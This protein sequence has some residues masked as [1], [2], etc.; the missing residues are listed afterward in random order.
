MIIF[1][2]LFIIV[3]QQQWLELTPLLILFGLTIFTT[4][5]AHHATMIVLMVYVETQI[6]Y[7]PFIQLLI[8]MQPQASSRWTIMMAKLSGLNKSWMSLLL[9]TTI[10]SL[11]KVSWMPI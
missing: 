11:S 9:S 1:P 10:L 6:M 7:M 4:M 2:Q 8:P 3:H 5:L